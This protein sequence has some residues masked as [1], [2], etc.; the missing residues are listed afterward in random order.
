[1]KKYY[2]M[3]KR[4]D[5]I[6]IILLVLLSLLPYVIFSMQQAQN[7]SADSSRVAVISIDNEEVERVT[8]TGNEG[9]DVFDIQESGSHINTVE[10]HDDRI[11]MKSATCSDQ[12]CVRTGYISKPGE[13][14]VCLPH[15]VIIEIQTEND[16]TDDL[17][18]SS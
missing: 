7:V 5:I 17:I 8:L 2:N 13:T 11:R 18:I 4:W 1:M 9:T 16:D 12:V 10:V 3:V 14:I 6:L 15:K